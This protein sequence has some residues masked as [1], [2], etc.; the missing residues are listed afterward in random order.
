MRIDHIVCFK[1]KDGTKPEMIERHMQSFAALS[2]MIP[3]IAGYTAGRTCKVSYE[4]TADYD[5]MHCVKFASQEALETYFF[6]EAHQAFIEENK[7]LWQDVIV[8]NA[9]IQ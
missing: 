7:D 6:H 5:V 9:D 4:K 3:E 1:F 8:I 2:G